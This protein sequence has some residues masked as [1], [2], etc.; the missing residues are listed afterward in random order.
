MISR[1]A[2]ESTELAG[3]TVRFSHDGPA[4]EWICELCETRSR[5][6]WVDPTKAW[7]RA[8]SHAVTHQRVNR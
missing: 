2:R 3:V 5:R 1:G 6:L 7:Q 4:Y 8:Y